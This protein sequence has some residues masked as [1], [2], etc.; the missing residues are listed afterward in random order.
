MRKQTKIAAVASAAALLAIGASM[1][2]FAAGWTPN[3]DGTWTYEDADGEAVEGWKTWNHD[4]QR[5]YIDPDTGL[6]AA[7][8]I[9]EVDSGEYYYFHSNGAMAKNEWIELD[10]SAVVEMLD[11]D[12]D[13]LYDPNTPDSYYFYADKNGQLITGDGESLSKKVPVGN[14]SSKTAQFVFDEYG[15]MMTGWIDTDDNY[16]YCYPEKTDKYVLGQPVVKGWINLTEVDLGDNE[17]LEELV[18]DT[19]SDQDDV[20]FYF[21][22]NGKNVVS[23]VDDADKPKY[24]L[25]ENGVLKQN[26]LVVYKDKLYYAHSDGSFVTNEWRKTSNKNIFDG[27]DGKEHSYYFL[28]SGAAVGFGKTDETTVYYVDKVYYFFNDN[29]EL[30]K[31][32][33]VA[34]D[35]RTDAGVEITVN[36]TSGK[37][38]TN[39]AS[40]TSILSKVDGAAYYFDGD[41]NQVVGAQ[42]T[43]KVND[44]EYTGY[45]DNTGKVIDDKYAIID[46]AL[47]VYNETVGISVLQEQGAYD[48]S[49]VVVPA[50]T[51]IISY[52]KKGKPNGET[53]YKEDVNIVVDENGVLVKNGKNIEAKGE[54]KVTEFNTNSDGIGTE[55]K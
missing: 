48:Y 54:E 41:G 39:N 24:Y 25:D 32:A 22:G 10:S 18:Y 47:Y 35:P 6:M 30:L 16:M 49:Y 26:T 51:K 21:D 11:L 38:T 13:E 29:G 20:Y 4:G 40:K 3:A 33:L 9:K 52:S 27:A 28:S 12:E 1:T 55:V 44:I 15:R 43:C 50:K 37:L 5:Y 7:S 19:Y 45:V 23:N 2:A 14:G 36:G 42:F 17:A 46:K 53:T 8:T 34:A 31:N